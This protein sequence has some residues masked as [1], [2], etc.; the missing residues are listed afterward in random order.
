MCEA[1]GKTWIALID[2]LCAIEQRQK[3]EAERF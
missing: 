3:T 1:C 2:Q